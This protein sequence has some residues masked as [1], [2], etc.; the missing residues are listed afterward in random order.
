MIHI[1]IFIKILP[2]LQMTSTIGFTWQIAITTCSI[3]ETKLLMP[4]KNSTLLSLPPKH[5][6]PDSQLIPIQK[7]LTTQKWFVFKYDGAL[8]HFLDTSLPYKPLDPRL[9]VPMERL[10]QKNRHRE[11]IEG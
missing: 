4:L 11:D 10:E 7:T 1:L 2:C 8:R 3:G 6:K 5:A 9:M